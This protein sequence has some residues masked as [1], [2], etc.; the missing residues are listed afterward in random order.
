M[1]GMT[2]LPYAC[3]SSVLGDLGRTVPAK[4]LTRIHLCPI[5]IHEGCEVWGNRS[6][7]KWTAEE[8][9]VSQEP[10]ITCPAAPP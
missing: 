8:I 1:L 6:S 5:N 9:N 3:G 7:R 4:I 2:D 10:A